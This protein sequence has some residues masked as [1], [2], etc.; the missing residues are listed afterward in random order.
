MR[1]PII[2]GLLGT[3]L[4]EAE[5]VFLQKNKPLGVLLLAR[6]FD[7]TSTDWIEIAKNLVSDIYNCINEKQVLITLD[8][9]GGRVHRTPGG[10]THFSTAREYKDSAFETGQIMASEIKQFGCNLSWAPVCDIDSNPDNPIIGTRAFACTADEVI[11]PAIEMMKGLHSKNVLSCAKHFPG[12]G[13]TNLDSHLALP[14]VDKSL[15]EIKQ[16]ELIPF[17]AII[18]AGVP[19]IMTAHILYPQID[20][21]NPATFSKF[22]LQEILRDELQFKGVTISDDIEMK[23]VSNRFETPQGFHQ[24]IDAGCDVFIVSR[25]FHTDGKFLEIAAEAYKTLPKEL[26]RNLSESITRIQ[27]LF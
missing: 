23:A 19:T 4:S 26:S 9:E 2:I 27:M 13:D 17:Q 8:H 15:E 25:H 21:E 5:K 16:C 7:Y 3:T 6:N 24:A 12:H 11:K 14:S 1:L 10:I 18:N 20:K 22:W